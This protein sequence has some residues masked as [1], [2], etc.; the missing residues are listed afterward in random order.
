MCIIIDTNKMS[1]FLKDHSS[2]DME[3]IHT[4]LS[5]RWGPL[6]YTA[7]GKYGEE[8]KSVKN[9]FQEYARSGR[10]HLVDKSKI[11]PEEN[12]LQTIKL[13]KSNDIHILALARASGAR[14][15]YTEDKTLMADF[16]KKEIIDKPRGS[17]Y[18]SAKNKN[19]LKKD[20]CKISKKGK[21][22]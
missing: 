2:V 7:Y 8:L 18:S 12:K 9:R 11:I 15:L 19:L 20:L 14:L 10:V 5:K 3:P 22:S 21:G 13:H 6:V 1:A 17:I 4:W 16:K